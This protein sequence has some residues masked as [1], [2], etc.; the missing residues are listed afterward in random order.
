MSDAIDRLYVEIAKAAG[1]GMLPRGGKFTNRNDW[2]DSR[3]RR[4][5][6]GGFLV[7]VKE[8]GQDFHSTGKVGRN[9]KTGKR[10]A[11]Y[12]RRYTDKGGRKEARTWADVR[13]K[14]Y[15]D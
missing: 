5:P 13:G 4:N 9:V 2:M 14:T 1:K 11:E 6:S 12:S 8:G 10:V 3:G 7:S 15:G